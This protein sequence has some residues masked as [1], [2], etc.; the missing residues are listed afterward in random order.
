MA[1]K[2][3]EIYKRAVIMKD[4]GKIKIQERTISRQG[5]SSPCPGEGRCALQGWWMLGGMDLGGQTC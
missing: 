3:P 2:D 1:I 4:N 5:R